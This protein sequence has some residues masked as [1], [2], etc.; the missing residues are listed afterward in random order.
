[1]HRKRVMLIFHGGIVGKPIAYQLIK[2][3]D[4]VINI[5]QARIFP[6][7]DG[8]LIIE[9]INEDEKQIIDGINY[10]EEEGVIVRELS[11][12]ILFDENSCINCGVCTG[13]CKTGALT[14]AQKTWELVVDQE[15]CLLCEMCIPTCPVNALSMENIKSGL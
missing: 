10:L 4:I 6:E 2:R 13:V 1:M 11:E 12:T 15:K 14:M 3:Y 9:M 5:L 7:E 8:Q